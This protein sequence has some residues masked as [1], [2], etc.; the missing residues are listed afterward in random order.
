MNCLS[1]VRC[2]RLPL[3]CLDPSRSARQ[4]SCP[5][6]PHASTPSFM[7]T[8]LVV[9]QRFVL[10][11]TFV[12]P[13]CGIHQAPRNTAFRLFEHSWLVYGAPCA[14]S[15]LKIEICFVHA[16]NSPSRIESVLLSL[17]ET[18]ALE[19]RPRCA[20]PGITVDRLLPPK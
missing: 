2:P 12:E 10:A 13:D 1:P 9:D 11:A 4:L 20:G 14:G 6:G 7:A 18:T 3:A 17:S 16:Q 15:L 8:A 19:L 5:C